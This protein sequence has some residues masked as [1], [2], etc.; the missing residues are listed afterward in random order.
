MFRGGFSVG[1][2]WSCCERL[3]LD[4]ARREM[5]QGRRGDV[6]K[7]KESEVTHRRFRVRTRIG[8]VEKRLGR[9]WGYSDR[10]PRCHNLHHDHNHRQ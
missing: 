1:C 4:G 9:A 7:R 5:S 3:Q 2:S 6:S 10:A 8:L